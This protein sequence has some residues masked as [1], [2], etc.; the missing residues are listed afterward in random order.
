[1]LDLCAAPGAK[2]THLAALMQD[3]GGLRA[4][5]R[6]PGRARALEGTLARMRVSCGQV[7]VAD[8]ATYAPAPTGDAPSLGG[9]S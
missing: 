6:H 2:T 4:V 7:V 9:W 8:A 3:T 5:E 1:M